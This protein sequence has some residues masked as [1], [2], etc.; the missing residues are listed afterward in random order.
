MWWFVACLKA[1]KP[2]WEH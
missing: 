2:R 1:L